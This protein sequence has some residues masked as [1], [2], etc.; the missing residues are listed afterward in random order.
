MLRGVKAIG[1]A[2]AARENKTL[3]DLYFCLGEDHP[4][5]RITPTRLPE[6]RRVYAWYLRVP[7]LL[8][9][10]RH[11]APALER[12]LAQSVAAGHTGELK[13]NF[14][15]EGLRLAFEGGRLAAIEPWMPEHADDGSAGFPGQTFLQI[16]FGYRSMEALR[17]AFPDCWCD[18]DDA[19]AL[20][21]ALFPKQR[22]VFW[23]WA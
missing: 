9:F 11:I 4:F 18:G 1:E 10:L 14:Y 13:L 3:T 5:C 21:E 8:G 16:L 19:R 2:L 22:S 20:L 23:P 6:V 12:R 15:R 17:S 7:D